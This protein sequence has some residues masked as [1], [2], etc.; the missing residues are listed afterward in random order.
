MDDD[1]STDTN[2]LSTV[3]QYVHTPTKGC[4]GSNQALPPLSGLEPLPKQAATGDMIMVVDA[5]W[6]A[7]KECQEGTCEQA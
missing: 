1:P 3:S 5:P 4:Y 6:E 7:W 2:G